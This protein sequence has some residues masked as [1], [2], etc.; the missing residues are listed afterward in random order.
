MTFHHAD[1]V[2]VVPDDWLPSKRAAATYF[3][4]AASQWPTDVVAIDDIEP[5]RRPIGV[6]VDGGEPPMTAKDRTGRIFQGFGA[7]IPLD[8][9]HL[10]PRRCR[11]ADGRYF[12]A[13][14]THRLYASIAFGYTSIPVIFI[15]DSLRCFNE[16]AYQA[17]LRR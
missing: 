2:F 13:D 14:G 16:E 3:T 17:R 6:F 4:P 7:N 10:C 5:P 1:F 15:D 12:L 8:P 11:S 9:V